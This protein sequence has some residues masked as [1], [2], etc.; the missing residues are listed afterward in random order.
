MQERGISGAAEDAAIYTRV[1]GLLIEDDLA[2]YSKIGI[3]VVE[4]RVLLTGVVPDADT[5]IRAVRLAWQAKGVREI[6]NEIVVDK[7]DSAAKAQDAWIAAQLSGRLLFDKEIAS[8]NYSV[9]AVRGVVY[10]MGVAQNQDE[11]DK[12]LRHARDIKYV[13]RIVNYV[14]LRND[15]RRQP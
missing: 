11:L 3:E 7:A 1:N 2:L 4:G 15:P 6:I 8:I 12:V 10:L 9:D 14:R 5:R 13:R